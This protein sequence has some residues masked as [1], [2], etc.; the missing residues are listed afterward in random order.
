MVGCA[1]IG[2]SFIG[3]KEEGLVATVVDL[4]DKHG[5]ADRA[6]KLIADEVG[7]G[8]IGWGLTGSGDA[9]CIVAVGFKK[10]TADLIRA[11]SGGDDG[12]GGSGELG[13]GVEGFDLY[14]LDGIG[15]WKLSPGGVAD[16]AEVAIGHGRAVLRVF[17]SFAHQ[18]R[19][20]PVT[21]WTVPEM[22]PAPL[23]AKSEVKL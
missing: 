10:R 5:A 1:A 23:C 17:E 14:F 9:Q 18:G 6:A 13:A 11:G 22:E 21:S 3:D 15:V 2:A 7:S 8:E 20:A 12:G 19:E 4:G 16:A